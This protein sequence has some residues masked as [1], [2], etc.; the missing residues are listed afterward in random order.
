MNNSPFVVYVDES[1][2][3]GL[4]NFDP[5]N[6]IFSLCAAVYAREH[7]LAKELPTFAELKFRHWWH[8]AVVFHS[9]KIRQRLGHFKSLSEAKDLDLFL[10]SMTDFFQKSV[11]T[12]VAAAID[13][14]RHKQQ[15]FN[16]ADP[17]SLAI[18]F[19]LER[20]YLLIRDRCKADETTMFVFERRGRADDKRVEERFQKICAGANFLGKPLPFA[21]CFAGKEEN[22]TGLQVADLIAYPIAR[23]VETRNDD[24]KDWACIKHLFRKSPSG[25]IDGWGLKVFP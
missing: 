21:I 11:C 2:D 14:P 5:G 8:D 18:E 10:T 16:P 3:Q 9:Y 19:I 15:Y 7:Y 17:Y 12:I 4:D 23:Y 13:K 22:I 24:R 25:K 6:P 20:T 1:G